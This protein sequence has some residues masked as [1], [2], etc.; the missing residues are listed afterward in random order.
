MLYAGVGVQWTNL[1][2]PVSVDDNVSFGLL[3]LMF[4]VDSFIHLIIM[5]YVEAVFPGS[6]GV[7]QKPYFFVLVCF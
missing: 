6:F 3:L 5:W 7:P 2:E 4:I 1:Y